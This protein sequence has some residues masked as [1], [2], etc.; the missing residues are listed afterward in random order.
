LVKVVERDTFPCIQDS[1]KNHCSSSHSLERQPD[2]DETSKLYPPYTLPYKDPGEDVFI[3]F[4]Q[5]IASSSAVS[6]P[7]VTNNSQT[8][9]LPRSCPY[10]LR[11][12][13]ANGFVY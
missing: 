13:N 10:D 8:G 7:A 3:P 1:S 12:R 9:V 11:P 6:I 2:E 4:N 5:Q